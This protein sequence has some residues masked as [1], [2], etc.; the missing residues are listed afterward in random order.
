MNYYIINN[1]IKG[2]AKLLG[3]DYNYQ[4]LTPTQKTFYE[5]N[6]TA[7]VNE[8]LAKKLNTPAEPTLQDLKNTKKHIV[9]N[10]FVLLLEQGYFDE[11]ENIRLAIKDEDRT[12]FSQLLSMLK[13]AEELQ[14]DTPETIEIADKHSKL[15]SLSILNLKALLLRYGFYYQYFWS[16]TVAKKNQIDACTTIEELNLIEG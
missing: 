6:P 10:D 16:N 9:D 4:K 3:A 14:A 2:F 12:A 11:E 8:V 1:K 15:H 5:A 7:S 13:L